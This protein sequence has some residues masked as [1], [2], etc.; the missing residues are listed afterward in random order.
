MWPGGGLGSHHGGA[1]EPT[2]D[3]V[4]KKFLKR[5]PPPSRLTLEQCSLVWEPGAKNEK[6]FTEALSGGD[7][8]CHV[9]KL[10]WLDLETPVHKGW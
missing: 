9:P 1:T 8:N 5:Q 4:K 7:R 6:L 2:T 3:T 10:V